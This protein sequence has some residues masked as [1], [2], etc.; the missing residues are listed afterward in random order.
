MQKLPQLLPSLQSHQHLGILPNATTICA[1]WSHYSPCLH[2]ASFT[3]C[4]LPFGCGNTVMVRENDEG[5]TY[6]NFLH[7]QWLIIPHNTVLKVILNSLALQLSMKMSFWFLHH[8][9]ELTCSCCIASIAVT[10]LLSVMS[11]HWWM[12]TRL[13]SWCPFSVWKSIIISIPIPP[14]ILWLTLIWVTLNN[15]ANEH[16]FHAILAYQ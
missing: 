2:H 15:F 3:S 8:P 6:T 14:W 5:C 9:L 1:R 4:K 11:F 16:T 10:R 12:C 13:C 7:Y